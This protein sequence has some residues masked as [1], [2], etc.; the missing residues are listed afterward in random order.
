MQIAGHAITIELR[1]LQE[2]SQESTGPQL[3][4]TSFALHTAGQVE[5]KMQAP[6]LFLTNPVLQKQPT[7]QT[8]GQ[9]TAAKLCNS[10]VRSPQ[11]DPQ[12]V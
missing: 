11:P 3:L 6:A 4:K 10:H 7:L 8:A 2:A 1:F 12:L 9:R 5:D